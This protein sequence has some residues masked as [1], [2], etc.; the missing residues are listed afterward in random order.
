MLFVF[1]TIMCF[2]ANSLPFLLVARAL[3][4]LG[5]AAALSMMSAMIRN[6]DPK[7]LWGRGI[8]TNT[9][10]VTIASAGAPTIGGLIVTLSDWRYVFALAAPLAL[11]SLWLGRKA[12]PDIAP[13]ETPYNLDGAMLNMATFGLVFVGLESLVHGDSPVISVAII[14]AGVVF[15]VWFVRHELGES[16]PILPVDLLA[17]PVLALSFA[18]SFFIFIASMLQTVSLP[19]RLQH[20][21]GFTP[22][23]VGAVLSP[24]PLTM[25]VMS[26]LA[27]LLSDKVSPGLLGAIGT[28]VLAA[29]LIMTA[30]PPAHPTYWDFAW[31]MS[32]CGA[33]MSLF[34][35]PNSRLIMSETPRERAAT[36]GGLISTT[37][38]SGQTLG[39]TLVA[40][41]LAMG[42]GTSPIP[43]LVGA[44]CAL[45][46]A[47]LSISRVRISGV[48]E[49]NAPPTEAPT[50]DAF[51]YRMR[52]KNFGC[53]V[54]AA[55]PRN[56]T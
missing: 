54:L 37:R 31:R 46:A 39:A 9:V 2:F 30:Y 43:I 36:T 12:L 42:L 41:L 34:L 49:K 6:I 19:F 3:Q 21:Y 29:A 13:I 23:E 26:P 16:R 55:T 40:A 44:A 17:R 38:M 47:A 27:S 10:V 52:S 4:A 32:M 5:A 51:F 35:A 7:G 33:G 18:A 25:M 53:D 28:T 15:A 22:G 14:L 1:A 11:L 45:T 20:L 56:G 48:A 50:C 8:A 24:S